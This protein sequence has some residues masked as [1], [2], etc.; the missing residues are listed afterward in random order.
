[1]AK[2]KWQS[3]GKNKNKRKR[4]SVLLL[5]ITSSVIFNSN[6]MLHGREIFWK[7]F[8]W[9]CF[10]GYYIVENIEVIFKPFPPFCLLIG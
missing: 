6:I 1:M 2:T 3:H 5:K 4:V 7:Y 9:S 8:C 10:K